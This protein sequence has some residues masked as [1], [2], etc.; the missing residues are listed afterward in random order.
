[1]GL[2]VEE[3]KSCRGVLPG[4]R[5][6]CDY[7]V[8]LVEKLSLLEAVALS[9]TELFAP[10]LMSKRIAVWEEHYPWVDQKALAYFRTRVSRA[11]YDCKG[12]LEF[13]LA[14]ATTY[15]LQERCVKALIAKTQI[16]WHILDGLSFAYTAQGLEVQDHSS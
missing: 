6:A 15:E 2:D 5:M 3:V 16:L 12:A 13:V 4:V 9:L 1:M 7:Y 8:N 11:A 10:D 14:H